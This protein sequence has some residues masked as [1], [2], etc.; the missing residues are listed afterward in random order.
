MVKTRPG[1]LGLRWGFV[2]TKAL[3]AAMAA[4]FVAG[5]MNLVPFYL[6][7]NQ[8]RLWL[9]AHIYFRATESWVQGLDPWAT[10]WQDVPFAA[11]PHA[12]LLNLPFVPLG[13][14]LAVGAWVALN[15]ASV[16]YLLRRFRLPFWWAFFHPLTEGF[17]AASPDIT[18]A[19]MALIGGSAIA[20]VAKPYSIPAILAARRWRSII[21]AAVA[22]I[23]TAPLL[24]WSYFLGATD[25]VANAFRDYTVTVSA[26]GAPLLMAT[27]AAALVSLGRSKGLMLTTPGLLA[28]QPHYVV[29]SLEAIARSPILAV[30]MALPMEH[31]AAVGV[32]AYA[33]S[34]KASA[35]LQGWA[36]AKLNREAE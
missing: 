23:V 30:S 21:V 17:L 27:T 35:P 10:S 24:P 2:A 13:E 19:A 5:N 28:Q 32:I 36:S 8:D 6:W 1:W 15:A 25:R 29:F 34:T 12:L 18:L 4:I 14:D 20:A 22:L 3:S 11:P 7:P 9:D 26:F 33:I 31:L 16:V